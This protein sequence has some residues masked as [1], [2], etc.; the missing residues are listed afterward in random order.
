MVLQE[1]GNEKLCGTFLLWRADGGA[2]ALRE[3]GLMPIACTDGK[4]DFVLIYV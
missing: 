1:V 2:V 3:A 4:P